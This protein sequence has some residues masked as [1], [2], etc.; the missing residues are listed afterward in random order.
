[1]L[2]KKS[3]FMLLVDKEYVSLVLTRDMSMMYSG[4]LSGLPF[5]IL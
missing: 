5:T 3:G 2:Y 4:D 1:M